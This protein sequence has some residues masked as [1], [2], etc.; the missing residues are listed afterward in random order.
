ML[1]TIMSLNE[2][3]II[4]KILSI[5]RN[6]VLFILK[7]LFYYVFI[8]FVYKASNELI[9]RILISPKLKRP[10]LFIPLCIYLVAIAIGFVW[11][12]YIGAGVRIKFARWFFIIPLISAIGMAVGYMNAKAIRKVREDVAKDYDDGIQDVTPIND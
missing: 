4:D 1:N 9:T 6:Q 5:N 10:Y 3:Q 8:W 11:S 12:L 7:P 2:Q